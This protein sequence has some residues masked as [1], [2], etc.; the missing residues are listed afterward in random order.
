MAV[1][2]LVIASQIHL[3]N[4]NSNDEKLARRSSNLYSFNLHILRL[5]IVPGK[6]SSRAIEALAFL[7]QDRATPSVSDNGQGFSPGNGFEPDDIGT[8]Y[9][10]HPMYPIPAVINAPHTEVERDESSSLQDMSLHPESYFDW[11]DLPLNDQLL[12]DGTLPILDE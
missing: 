1:E 12:F 4:S 6:Q 3:F 7:S 10:S 11:L 8:Y 5:M 2:S 9:T